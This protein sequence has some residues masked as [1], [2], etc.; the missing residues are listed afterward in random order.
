MNLG[1]L[2]RLVG[3]VDSCEVFQFSA[4]CLSI[5]SFHVTALTFR[6]RGIDEDFDE[7]TGI[8]QLANHLTLRSEWRNKGDDHNQS[9][10]DHKFCD[11]ADTANVFYAIGLGKSEI[12]I[13]TVPNVVPV[14]NVSMLA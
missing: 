12:A 5:Q 3:A 4:P 13:K 11:F 9:G 8:E 14:E 1:E 10:V 6:Q 2:R 7:F